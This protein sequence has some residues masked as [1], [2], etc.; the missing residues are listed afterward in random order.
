[1]KRG[2]EEQEERVYTSTEFVPELRTA[3]GSLFNVWKE[4]GRKP[5]EFR[6]LLSEA[7]YAVPEKTLRTWASNV[8]AGGSAVS[9]AK[10]SGRPRSIS[11][12][13]VRLLVG[14]V[15]YQ[16]EHNVEVHLKTAKA[17]VGL[18]LPPVHRV[19]LVQVG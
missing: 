4:H 8:H 6:L 12:E 15:L 9:T 13:K 16:N 7:G 2:W 5:K 3:F 17:F 10:A 14:W 11:D 18:C 19:G 1:M